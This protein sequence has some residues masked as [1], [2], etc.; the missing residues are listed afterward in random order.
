VRAATGDQDRIICDSGPASI[1]GEH[2]ENGNPPYRHGIS[3]S[4]TFARGCPQFQ[5]IASKSIKG[6]N[7][8]DGGQTPIGT[9]DSVSEIFVVHHD[10]H[11]CLSVSFTAEPTSA[12]VSPPDQ[13]DSHPLF[14]CFGEA[15][16]D[17]GFDGS[18]SVAEISV[19]SKISARRMG[20]ALR[21]NSL[22]PAYRAWV[23]NLRL[24]RPM[25]SAHVLSL[26]LTLLMIQ[27]VLC[28]TA[29]SSWGCPQL[30]VQN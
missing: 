5:K 1:S 12:G 23:L 9:D 27:T 26:C 13:R 3:C 24:G 15:F 22:G 8:Q 11:V 28:K 30:A 7:T 25:A 16:Y 10:P 17:Q 21:K 29:H 6:N 20:Y 14:P 19:Y 2:D 4:L 18:T